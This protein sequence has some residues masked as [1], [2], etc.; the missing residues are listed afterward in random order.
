MCVYDTALKSVFIHKM[1]TYANHTLGINP[2]KDSALSL[3]VTNTP[4]MWKHK[5]LQN[6]SIQNNIST[7]T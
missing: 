4:R 1:S 5:I 7:H 6:A 3:K 2:G